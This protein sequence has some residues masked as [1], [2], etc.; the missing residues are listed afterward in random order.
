M[1]LL[2]WHILFTLF[3]FTPAIARDFGTFRGFSL[4][5]KYGILRIL[6]KFNA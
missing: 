2:A 4:F 6:G 5:N 1:T 3:E